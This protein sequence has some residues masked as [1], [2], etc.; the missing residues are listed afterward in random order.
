MHIQC[1]TCSKVNPA[2]AAYCYYDGRAL[3]NAGQS[4]PLRLGTRPFSLPFCFSDGQGCANYNQ[5]VLACDRR[6]NEAR[7]YLLNGTWESFF[8]SLGRPDLAV[9][10]MQSAKE[11]DP[12]LGLCRL[13]EGLPADA[14]ALRPAQL[15]LPSTE[16]NL[17]TLVPGKDH[18]IQLVIENQGMLV[19]RG[20]VMTDCDWLVFSDSQGNATQKLFQ[21]RDSYHLSVTVAGHKLRAGPKPLDGQIIIDTNGGREIVVVCAT[22]PVRPFPRGEIIGNVLAGARSPRELAVKAKLH[23]NE[24]AVQFEQGMVKAWYESNGWTYP[25]QGTQARGKGALMQFFEA[26]GLVKPPRL[27]IDTA[28]IDC[29]GEVGERLTKQ[30]VLRTEEARPVYADAQSDQRWI[31]V[32]P[33]KSQGKSVTI[34]LRIEIP[35]RPGETLHATVTCQGNGQQRFVVPVTL[36]VARP[37]RPSRK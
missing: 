27:E 25:I 37:Q 34:P 21:T 32:L 26:L 7:G 31:K 28:R 18:K 9:L 2:N 5:L 1:P 13:L 35:S 29:Q 11:P 17:G 33:A 22:V 20:S 3:L 36:T 4:G 24:A 12:D 14:E 16:E 10:A 6:W 30:V 23:P 19:L 8:S 15:S